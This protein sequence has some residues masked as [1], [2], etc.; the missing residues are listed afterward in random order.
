MLLSSPIFSVFRQGCDLKLNLKISTIKNIIKIACAVIIALYSWLS[1]IYWTPGPD[2]S[3]LINT[4]KAVPNSPE[5]KA[6]I[7]YNVPIS[8]AF[9][10]K[11]HLSVH[12]DMLPPKTERLLLNL[13]LPSSELSLEVFLL[14]L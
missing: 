1:A 7:K 12:K 6:K 14:F 5:N 10:D 13:C 4:E 2:S 8:F 11:N 9:D 3:N